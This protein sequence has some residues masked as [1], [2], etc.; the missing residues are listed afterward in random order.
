MLIKYNR[1]AS[2][3]FICIETSGYIWQYVVQVQQE[4]LEPHI[5]H[6]VTN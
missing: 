3:A 4:Q 2:L 1:T 5:N 6:E